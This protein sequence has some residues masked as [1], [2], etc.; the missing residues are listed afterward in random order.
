MHIS[1]G[2][3]T[4]LPAVGYTI[5][6]V[7]LTAVGVQKMKA[8][9][10]ENPEKKPLLAMG[11]AF[12]FL[13]SLIPI[14][15]F[16]GTCSHPAGSPLAAILLGPWIALTLTAMSLFL[17]AAF[18]AHGGFSTWGANVITL[19]VGG[20]FCGWLAFKAARQAG[21]SLVVSAALG[22]LIGDIMT[23]ATAGFSLSLVMA[24]GPNPQLSFSQY[25]VAIYAAYL[26][27]QGPIAIGE[28][29]L[30]GLLIGYVFKQR[31]EILQELKVVFTKAAIILAVF[32]TLSIPFSDR[33]YAEDSVLPSVSSEQ[34]AITEEE[35]GMAGMDEAVNEAMAEAA[36]LAARDPYIN[37]ESMGDVWNA[38]ML[39][40]GAICGFIFGRYWHML[41]GEDK[42]S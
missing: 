17:Q 19:G 40:A 34:P 20:A 23:Y 9:I 14:P 28:M 12:I 15:A 7:G 11:G 27:T 38:V 41:V 3:I 35:S 26:P 22:G 8:F 5:V 10:A 4:G 37:L 33:L 36:G 29:F 30:T 31:P 16:T 13:L 1:E 6:A 42:K 21:L 39:L 24:F 2:I 25:L 32:I 18:F